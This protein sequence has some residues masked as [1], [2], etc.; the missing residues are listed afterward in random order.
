MS[1]LYTHRYDSADHHRLGSI[2]LVVLTAE[3]DYIDSTPIGIRFIQAFTK[4][5]FAQH[6]ALGH[7]SSHGVHRIIKVSGHQ[8]QLTSRRQ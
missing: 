2:P 6:E 3:H 8:I 4:I 7:L 1:S 5:K